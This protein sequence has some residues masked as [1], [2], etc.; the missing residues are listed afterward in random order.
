L[1][2]CDSSSLHKQADPSFNVADLLDKDTKS[3]GMVLDVMEL[4]SGVKD[5]VA[6][7]A[8]KEKDGGETLMNLNKVSMALGENASCADVGKESQQPFEGGKDNAPGDE[9]CGEGYVIHDAVLVDELQ[10]SCVP[11]TLVDNVMSESVELATNVVGNYL[12][13]CFMEEVPDNNHPSEMGAKD[14]G[15]GSSGSLVDTMP[16]ITKAQRI[17]DN[18]H[19]SEMGAKDQGVGSGGSHV[20]TMP[21][22]TKAQRIPNTRYNNRVQDRL[23]KKIQDQQMSISKK[24]PLEGNSFPDQ[25]SFAVLVLDNIVAI[26][27]DMG[28]VIPPNKFDKVDLLRDIEIARHALS[29]K[30]NLPIS[31]IESSDKVESLIPCEGVPLLE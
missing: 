13:A 29:N 7:P 15:V 3:K 19:P 10:S 9:S 30:Q 17:P 21:K 25:N 12:V 11:Q 16:K 8:D 18:N 5:K 22:I 23:V 14:Q 26:P 6:S 2:K 20:D 1:V 27:D 31:N 24:R 28:V 4:V